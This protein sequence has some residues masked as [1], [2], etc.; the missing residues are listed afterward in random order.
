MFSDWT[1][2]FFIAGLRP[3]SIIRVELDGDTAHEA[4]RF[5]MGARIRELEQGPNGAIWVLEDGKS[6]RL[7]KLSKPK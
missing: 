4:E 5:D 6:G 1:G 3:K 7:L 2:S